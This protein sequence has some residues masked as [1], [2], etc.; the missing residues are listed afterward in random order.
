MDRPGA[1]RAQPK[2]LD[3][4]FNALHSVNK[5]ESWDMISTV[6][7]LRAELK[8]RGLP[9]TG[10]REQLVERINDHNKSIMASAG[11]LEIYHRKLDVYQ[12]QTLVEV[13]PFEQFP[14]FPIE[15]RLI[16]WEF[17]L[18]EPRILSV[19]ELR[20]SDGKLH[21]P[22]DD[23]HPNPAALSA[24]RESRT[25]AL[26]SYRLCFGTTY[27]YANLSGGDILS[28]GPRWEGRYA[29]A[30][31]GY[32]DGRLGSDLCEG[33]GRGWV[34][35]DLAGSV[36][37]DLKEV[38]HVVYGPQAW[39]PYI[40]PWVNGAHL[41]KYLKPFPRL[42]QLSLVTEGSD[43]SDLKAFLHCDYPYTP[44]H[45]VLKD[46][47]LLGENGLHGAS[48][49]V[50]QIRKAFLEEELTEKDKESRIPEVRAV[51]M[52]RVPNIPGDDWK[53]DEG[54]PFYL[55]KPAPKPAIEPRRSARI[56]A[57]EHPDC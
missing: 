21:F 23:N 25:V 44:G 37:A 50:F 28:F 8:R 39:Y 53:L 40:G 16:V 48:Q 54:E 4:P 9:L 49:K 18:P 19:G 17:S 1:A 55:P 31:F 41:W 34:H 32:L 22:K 26:K 33:P 29:R 14:E 51:T 30:L 13:V 43:Y 38:T 6:A 42:Q 11:R 5:V 2:F 56:R 7:Q 20:R 57:L 10:K 46:N 15:I 24:C 47:L 12:K 27:L 52:E 45:L 36:V 35:H 3:N